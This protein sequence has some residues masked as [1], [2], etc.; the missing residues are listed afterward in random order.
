M[1][2]SFWKIPCRSYNVRLYIRKVKD[3]SRCQKYCLISSSFALT[4]FVA[5]AVSLSP[6]GMLTIWATLGTMLLIIPIVSL[7]APQGRFNTSLHWSMRIS[8]TAFGSMG[9]VF[10]IAVLA[11]V[12]GWKD[13]LTVF[14]SAHTDHGSTLALSV[15]GWLLL[16]IG[17]GTDWIMYRMFGPPQDQVSADMSYNSFAEHRVDLG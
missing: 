7:I 2:L 6:V 13:C 8:H 16:V 9:T 17:I 5:F 14:W 4:T 15:L 11:H 3:R 10:S 12:P 1:V